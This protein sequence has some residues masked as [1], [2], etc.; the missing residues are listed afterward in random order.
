MRPL[1]VMLMMLVS[2]CADGSLA[3]LCD[4]TERDRDRAAA[5]VA[6]EG[7]DSVVL[8][9]QPLISKTDAACAGIE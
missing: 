3:A 6:E 2:G 4:A 1:L 9:V 5:I 7:T 8:A